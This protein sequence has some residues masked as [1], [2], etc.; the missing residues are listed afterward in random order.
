VEQ[1][2]DV[3]NQSFEYIT[4][5]RALELLRGSTHLSLT[6]K[7]NPLAFKEMLLTS[8][9]AAKG[10]G[11]SGKNKKTPVAQ[12]QKEM[13][14]QRHS[15]PNTDAVSGMPPIINSK[16]TKD[17]GLAALASNPKQNKLLQVFKGLNILPRGNRCGQ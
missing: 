8:D 5:L 1:I 17:K 15:A 7:Y 2:L 12:L 11:G 10:S 13:A 14:K 4:H 9:S 16:V 3:N 6:V